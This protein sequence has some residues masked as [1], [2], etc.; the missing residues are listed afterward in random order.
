MWPVL[1]AGHETGDIEVVCETEHED[2]PRVGHGPS[3]NKY[4]AGQ[5]IPLQVSQLELEWCA[6]SLEFNLASDA[7]IFILT[8]L[9]HTYIGCQYF[10]TLFVS[11]FLRFLLQHCC[12]IPTL[13]DVSLHPH[14]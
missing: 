6:G 14:L 8:L 9:S 2:P 7:E 12:V 3:Q 5:A 13:L 10:C 4:T 11:S 1:L